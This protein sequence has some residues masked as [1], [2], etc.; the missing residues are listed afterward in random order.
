MGGDINYS[1][2][3]FGTPL[4]EAVMN[5]NIDVINYIIQ[6]GADLK[7]SNKHDNVPVELAIQKNH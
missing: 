1:D 6:N 5:N 7:I 3:N 2:D 4:L